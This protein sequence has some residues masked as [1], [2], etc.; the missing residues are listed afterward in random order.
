MLKNGFSW[1][2]ISI[3]APTKGATVTVTVIV[4]F[5]F[6]SIHAPTKGATGKLV[7]TDTIFKFQSTLPRRERL[8]PVV[9]PSTSSIY[10]NP[11]SHEG[12]D[13]EFC[14]SL[15]GIAN[16]NPRSH[17]GSD[18]FIGVGATILNDFNPRSHEGSDQNS[19]YYGV[20]RIYFNPR[21]HEG[22]DQQ[23]I[24]NPWLILRFQSTL[25]RRERPRILRFSCR[26][27]KFQ[28]TL[29]RRERLAKIASLPGLIFIS[30]HAPTKG[31]TIPRIIYKF[32]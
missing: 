10:F 19:F 16:F 12:S 13:P 21:S 27:S 17:E 22:S 32:L 15:V 9:S 3:H 30:I 28:S 14:D 2:N 26:Y 24:L 11:R 18:V 7:Q 25:P 5:A 23:V 4:C 31:A 8:S 1:L 20:I 6:I 29:P